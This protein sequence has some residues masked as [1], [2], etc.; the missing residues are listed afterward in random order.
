M[1]IGQ[2]FVDSEVIRQ[3]VEPYMAILKS[4]DI[5]C[6]FYAFKYLVPLAFVLLQGNGLLPAEASLPD[7]SRARKR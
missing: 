5:Y 7:R 6:S 2:L 3:L 4:D 1:L